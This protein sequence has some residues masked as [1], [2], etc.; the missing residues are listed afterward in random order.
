MKLEINIRS[1]DY[2]DS[3]PG[4]L[5]VYEYDGKHDSARVTVDGMFAKRR[6][7]A[8][9]VVM[10]VNILSTVSQSFLTKLYKSGAFAADSQRL[11]EYNKECDLCRFK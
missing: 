3:E 8:R 5:I 7:S 1:D 9:A 11:S 10:A 4:A 2:K 6:Y